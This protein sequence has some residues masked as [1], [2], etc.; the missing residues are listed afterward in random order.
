MS[1]R[2][3]VIIVFL[4]CVWGLYSG[5]GDDK[6]TNTKQSKVPQELIAYWT[7]QSV[8]FDGYPLDLG[9]SF[10]WKE[11]AVI[12]G[13]DIGADG[14]YTYK[15]FDADSSVIDT[16]SVNF[17]IDGNNFT[18]TPPLGEYITEGS[19]SIDSTQLTLTVIILGHTINITATK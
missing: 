13:M 4:L 5:C 2:Q 3:K 15:E 17:V 14:K 11:D 1:T 6:G 16:Y 12:C 7:F 8:T 18:V 9:E 19:W 10:G